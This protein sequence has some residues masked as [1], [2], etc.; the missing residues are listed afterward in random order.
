MSCEFVCLYIVVISEIIFVTFLGSYC[1][2]SNQLTSP[3]NNPSEL[4]SKAAHLCPR[5]WRPNMII[6]LLAALTDG[7]GSSLEAFVQLNTIF[8]T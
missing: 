2:N 5:L 1:I 7:L 6:D 3:K 4:G 8:I